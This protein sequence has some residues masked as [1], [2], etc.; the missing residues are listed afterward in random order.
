MTKLS[1]NRIT[2]YLL[3]TLLLAAPAFAQT[4]PR[5]LDKETF[6][7]MESVGSPQISPDG[8]TI[9][10]TSQVAAG[11]SLWT[12]P[13]DGSAAPTQL[14][15]GEDP[16]WAPNSRTVVFVRRV[17]GKRELSL[18]DVPSKTVKS[19]PLHLGSCSQPCW[20]R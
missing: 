15:A 5:L 17:S 2:F 4:K 11:F 19:I 6:M 12:V 3:A 7:E 14:V 13:A 8:K 10:F 20:S 16:S 9:I 18:L 1:I